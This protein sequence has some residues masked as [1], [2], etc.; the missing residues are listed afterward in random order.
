M[1]TP[2]ATHAACCSVILSRMYY[3]HSFTVQ[4]HFIMKLWNSLAEDGWINWCHDPRDSDSYRGQSC[5]VAELQVILM[6]S[7]QPT[8]RFKTHSRPCSTGIVPFHNQ[9]NPRPPVATAT[10]TH[11]NSRRN[12]HLDEHTPTKLPTIA[13]YLKSRSLMACIVHQ[14]SCL[15]CPFQVHKEP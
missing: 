7:R 5:S 6:S 9:F 12:L 10:P 8:V 13:Y 3:V 2:K 15:L 14:T 11:G 1:I 4:R